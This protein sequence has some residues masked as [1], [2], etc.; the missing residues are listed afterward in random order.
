MFQFKFKGALKQGNFQ[1][2]TPPGAEPGTIKAH[3]DEPKP[4]ITTFAYG[5]SEFV[6]GVID[7]LDKISIL[8]ESWPVTWI[9]VTGLGDDKRL[10]ELSKKLNLHALALEDV[11]DQHQ[12][13]KVE[14]YDTN[15][16]IV[17]KMLEVVDEVLSS[18]Q[19]SIFI[20]DRFVI[21]FQSHE[22]DC[23][24]HIRKRIRKGKNKIRSSG[25]D[26]LGYSILDAVVDAYFPALEEYGERLEILEDKILENADKRLIAELHQIKRDL[27]VLRRNIWPVREALNSLIR[28]TYPV[29]TEDTRVYLRD[30]YD[31]AVRIIDLIENFRQIAADL[32]DVYL[33]MASN[34]MNEVMKV[35]TVI[36]TIFIPPTF[37]AGV[38]GMNFNTDISPWNMPE[39]NS[40]F[41]YPLCLAIMA[42]MTTGVILFLYSR[43]WLNNS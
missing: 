6:E 38:Y 21:T 32:M 31:H 12:R 10:N 15:L 42:L 2:L 7:D 35:L 30:C 25:P 34:K 14:D 20:S 17:A 8:L 40:L 22:G 19:L 24:E 27:L 28:D 43:G 5:K 11:F 36:S 1:C 39:L 41:G 37:V 23:L 29:I 13:P 16:F 3:P 9:N 26:Y 33:S 4:V 18:E